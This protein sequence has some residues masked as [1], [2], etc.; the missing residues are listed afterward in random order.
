MH[1][2]FYPFTIL[3]EAHRFDFVS[4][5]D[6]AISKTIIYQRTNIPD[7]FQ[8]VMGDVHDSGMVDIYHVS[9]NGDMKKVLATVF[10]SMFTFLE[11]HIHATV[12]FAGS[13]HARTRLYQIAIARELAIASERYIV[14][15]FNGEH[16]EPFERNKP[17]QGFGIS[18]KK[19]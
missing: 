13:T 17:Y 12:V 3:N 18:L 1:Q 7:T 11:I 10:Q 5:G 4:V 19:N 9:D 16:F 6:H 14:Q 15:G 8:L 2:P